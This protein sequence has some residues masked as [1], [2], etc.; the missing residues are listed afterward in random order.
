MDDG[1]NLPADDSRAAR[2]RSDRPRHRLRTRQEYWRHFSEAFSH[3]PCRFPLYRQHHQ[4]WGQSCSY[5][6]RNEAG[7]WR[8]VACLHGML[9]SAVAYP[10]NVHFR[11]KITRAI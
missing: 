5:G 2:Q 11:T 4:H 6:C 10:A 9:R 7:D 1:A 3:C 8:V